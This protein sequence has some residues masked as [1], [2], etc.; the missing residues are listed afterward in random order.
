MLETV[1]RC[2]TL[3]NILAAILG[4][5]LALH[6]LGLVSISN[7]ILENLLPAILALVGMGYAEKCVRCFCEYKYGGVK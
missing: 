6:E 7:N 4:T 3:S 1:K 5:A 2:C